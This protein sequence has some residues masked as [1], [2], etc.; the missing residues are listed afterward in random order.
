MNKDFIKDAL[1]WGF[2]LWF[3]GYI[4]GIVLFMLV[5]SSML[6]WI[7][8]PVGTI[9]TLFVLFKKIKKNSLQYFFKLAVSWTLIAVI[10]DYLFLV[11]IFNP[12]DGYYKLDVYTYYTL[13]FILPV[14]AGFKRN[15]KTI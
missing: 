8:L 12:P 4:L 5:P 1:G 11:K 3:I 9:I 7:I 6:G 15:Y 14:L 10:F 13:T 2:A